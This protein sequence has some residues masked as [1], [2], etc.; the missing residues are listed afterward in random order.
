[1]VRILSNSLQELYEEDRTI[2][3]EVLLK[4][5][6]RKRCNIR[7]SAEPKSAMTPMDLYEQHKRAVVVVGSIYRCEKCTR[8]HI[9]TASG[10]LVTSDGVMFTNYHVV[11]N[12]ETKAMGVMTYDGKV[13]PVKEVLAAEESGD[14]AVLQLEGS[15]FPYLGLLQESPVGSK[16]WII[17]SPN[18]QLYTFT[19]GI[20][21]AHVVKTWKGV[22]TKRIAVTADFGVGSSGAPLFNEC[23]NVVGMVASTRAVRTKTGCRHAHT[24]MVF[25]HCIPAELLLGLFTD[26]SRTNAGKSVEPS[27]RSDG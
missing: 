22:Q 2:K 25:K 13:Y 26:G 21:S 18:R 9:R 20:I 11:D 27:H 10:F 7:L 8:W 16:V 1:M 24:Q 23:G 19:E 5:L 6:S 15:G 4:Q 3:T 14:I 17:S 12:P